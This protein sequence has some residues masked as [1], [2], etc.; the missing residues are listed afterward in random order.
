MEDDRLRRIRELEETQKEMQAQLQQMTTNIELMKRDI[1]SIA[2]DIA[3]IRAPFVFIFRILGGA[4][5]TA[6]GAWI[7]SGGLSNVGK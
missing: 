5:L 3:K 7:I 2:D 1:S 4:A 6:L